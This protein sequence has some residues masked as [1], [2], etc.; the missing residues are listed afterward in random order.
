MEF[1]SFDI[2]GPVEIVPRK[3]EDSRGYF[4]EIFRVEPFAVHAGK[5][6]FVQDNQSLSVRPG[7]IRG[8]H[9]QTEPAAQGKLVRCLSGSVLD[10]AVD[11]RKDSPSYGRWIAVTL[12]PDTNNQ[13][14]IPVGFGH[15]FCTLE[16]NSVISYRVTNYYSPDHDKGVAWDDSDIG[17]DWPAIADPETLSAKDRVQPK[18]ADLEAYFPVEGH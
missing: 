6:E 5:V 2:Q 9:F 12:N 13:L 11:L 18:L 15:A 8:I 3:I 1:R 16:P 10:V 7:T 4:S 14:W 17:I